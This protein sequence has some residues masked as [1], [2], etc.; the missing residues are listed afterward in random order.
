MKN[1]DEKA[2]ATAN[3]VKQRKRRRVLNSD[4]EPALAT[5][6]DVCKFL[7]IAR[8]SVYNMG[9]RGEIKFVKIGS[10]TRVRWSD[11][12][13]LVKAANEAA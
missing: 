3:S 7:A 12:H 8:N 5:I 10:L 4:V 2:A 13:A 9:Y 1:R 11:L 6:D